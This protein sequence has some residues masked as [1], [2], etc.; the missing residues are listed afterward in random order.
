MEGDYF[1]TP[2]TAT[3]SVEDANAGQPKCVSVTLQQ[4][5]QV[6]NTET[7]LL[8]MTSPQSTSG[9]DATLLIID[10]DG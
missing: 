10:D 1:R 5:T 7:V 6:E 3:I 4:D 2:V 9:D 8:N